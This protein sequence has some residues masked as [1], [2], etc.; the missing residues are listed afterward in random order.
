M[1]LN[2]YK[3]ADEGGAMKIRYVQND[4]SEALIYVTPYQDVCV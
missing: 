4:Y 3:T 2:V 1:W